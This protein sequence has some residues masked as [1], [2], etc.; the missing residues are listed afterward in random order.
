MIQPKLSIIVPSYNNAD[1]LTILLESIKSQKFT[2]F[3]LLIIDGNS[4]D[5]TRKTIKD[6]HPLVSYFVSEN[7]NGIYDA[8]NKGIL[9]S[10]GEWLYFIG[11]DDEFYSPT[12]LL[13]VF[14]QE[15]TTASVM[16]GKIFNKTKQKTEGEVIQ[17]K[18]ELITTSIWHQSVFYRRS[19]FDK[20]GLYDLNYPIAADVV[21]NISCFSQIFRHW[22]F[23]DVIVSTFS[24]DGVSSRTVD[25]QYHKNQKALFKKWF[26]GVDDHLIYSGLQHHLYHQI[27]LGNYM[28]ALR[29]YCILF[30]KTKDRFSILRNSMYYLKQR[31]TS[32]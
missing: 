2:D 29:E 32:K 6:Y 13:D 15:V 25:L 3:E 12:A 27:K 8:M 11:C 22:M 14:K 30:I 4:T 20:F 23:I 28:E 26:L 5:N 31:I 1:K 17:T 10:K 19:V 16:Y 24:G 7:D 18:T 9:A 21:F